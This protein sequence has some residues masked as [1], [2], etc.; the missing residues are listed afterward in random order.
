VTVLAVLLLI[1]L[2]LEARGR[3]L[4]I[5]HDLFPLSLGSVEGF[6]HRLLAIRVVACC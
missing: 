3:P 6:R 2:L 4:A 1:I 5:V